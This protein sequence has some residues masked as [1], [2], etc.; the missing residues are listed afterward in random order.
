M[1]I[2]E[3]DLPD[4]IWNE[5][6]DVSCRLGFAFDLVGY[7]RLQCHRS[8]FVLLHFKL[9]FCRC[10]I[11][12][13]T[14]NRLKMKRRSRADFW[15]HLLR[16]LFRFNS[17]YKESRCRAIDVEFGRYSWLTCSR[18]VSF[19]FE[20]ELYWLADLCRSRANATCKQS[21]SPSST[22]TDPIATCR[23]LSFN[24]PLTKKVKA[25]RV[26]SSKV[27]L[28][29]T[30]ITSLLFFALSLSLFLRFGQ[31]LLVHLARSSS[32]A[33]P[34]SFRHISS[35]SNH[36]SMSRLRS[37]VVHN[38]KTSSTIH[39]KPWMRN[40]S[41][42]CHRSACKRFVHAS[43]QLLKLIIFFIISAFS[44]VFS[45]VS[46]WPNS[47]HSHLLPFANS[48]L[49]RCQQPISILF[50]EFLRITFAPW[51]C[52]CHRFRM[53]KKANYFYSL[54]QVKMISNHRAS[55]NASLALL[56]IFEMWNVS[57]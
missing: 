30:Q 22:T 9:I 13:E 27:P 54:G 31:L 46:L 24:W 17:I 14:K 43:S 37:F 33:S 53:T 19:A 26:Y 44:S 21:L 28:C 20:H 3:F 29:F 45:S 18:F 10:S 1:S 25:G 4:L 55:N 49:K 23:R 12:Y 36:L 32:A 7:K 5:R 48:T 11:H 39:I 8:L 15:F 6:D 34:A 42:F 47:N 41:G 57:I 40:W 56:L 52:D 51:S 35:A 16:L 2:I 38:Q 50:F